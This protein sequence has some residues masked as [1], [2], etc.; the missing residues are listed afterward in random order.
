MRF[1]VLFV[2]A[3]LAGHVSFASNPAVYDG[4]TFTMNGERIRV[5]GIDAPEIRGKCDYEKRLA[6]QSRDRLREILNDP[7]TVSRQ[8]KDRYGRTL[9]HVY[10]DGVN[11]GSTLIAEGLAVPWAGKRHVWC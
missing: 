10:V 5:L 8:G 2:L 11:V 9:A 7:F 4:D 1:L 6:I 3:L